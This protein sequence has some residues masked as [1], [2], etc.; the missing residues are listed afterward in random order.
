M[1]SKLEKKGLFIIILFIVFVVTGILY[2]QTSNQGN[3]WYKLSTNKTTI[4]LNSAWISSS[5]I[6]S[7]IYEHGVCKTYASSTSTGVFVPTK[8]LNEWALFRTN[9]PS[10]I[11]LNDCPVSCWITFCSAGKCSIDSLNQALGKIIKYEN[12]ATQKC[13]CFD[14]WKY[15]YLWN[16]SSICSWAGDPTYYFKAK[17]NSDW[18]WTYYNT[19]NQIINDPPSWVD[20]C[21]ISS[22][23]CT[24]K[25]SL[26]WS[27]TTYIQH[28]A[29]V[30]AYQ[31]SSVPS[32]SSC[33][34]QTRQCINWLLGWSYQYQAC[35]EQWYTCK[36]TDPVCTQTIYA[37]RCYNT[38]TIWAYICGDWDHKASCTS[39]GWYW[40]GW[41]ASWEGWSVGVCEAC[42]STSQCPVNFY[43]HSTH[44]ICWPSYGPPC[45]L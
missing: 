11:T 42:S 27:A 19:N 23:A 4:A 29:C 5:T 37:G 33:V 32:W 39:N 44:W 30:T 2:A 28:W 8:T 26:P 25:C 18:T 21:H 9:K 41:C 36:T 10:H 14:S 3:R 45:A 20:M 43:C 6:V 16:S 15:I 13:N 24:T 38:D 17:C 40:G 1:N 35:S 7:N 12:T 22:D 34:S 31:S